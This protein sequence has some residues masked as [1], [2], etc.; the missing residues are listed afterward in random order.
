MSGFISPSSPKLIYTP[1][2]GGASVD[3]NDPRRGM[4]GPVPRRHRKS[5]LEY[6]LDGDPRDDH[7][8]APL[9][10]SVKT[11]PSMRRQA[12]EERERAR[13]IDYLPYG[14]GRR[15]RMA[16][17]PQGEYYPDPQDVHEQSP[18]EYG[19]SAAAVPSESP[20]DT[21]SQAIADI[22]ERQDQQDV[23]MKKILETLQD[24]QG[25]QSPSKSKKGK[26]K[27]PPA[28]ESMV[29]PN[30]GHE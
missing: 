27:A 5:T 28:P 6:Q 7:N 18:R 17:P 13:E 29:E 30:G 14:P 9:Q 24:M 10:I 26:R 15:R 23:T 2:F 3:A 11:S 25:K 16:H 21:R 1:R 19:H 4:K 22:M 8:H 20:R 12:E